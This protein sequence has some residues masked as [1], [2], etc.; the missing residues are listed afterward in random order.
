MGAGT[1]VEMSAVATV[2]LVDDDV[3]L[4][5]SLDLIA[6]E[7]HLVRTATNGGD[8]GSPAAGTTPNPDPG[9]GERRNEHSTACKNHNQVIELRASQSL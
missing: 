3:G 9:A 7:G 4:P 2:L 6:A 8:V 5:G 1:R